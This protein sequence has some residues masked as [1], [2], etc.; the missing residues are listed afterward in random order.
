VATITKR[1][2]L[3]WQAKIR[4]KGYPPQSR[5][6]ETKA[7]AEVWARDIE[8]EM[9]RGIFVDRGEAESTTLYDALER[10]RREVTPRK[11][12]ADTETGRI[13]RWQA[14]T[15]SKSTLARI[16]GKDLAKFRDDRRAEGRAENTIRLDLALLSSLYET[17]RKEWGM[18]AL[19]NPVRMIKAPG[20]SNKRERRLSPE[21]EKWLLSGI[22]AAM[23]RT[24]TIRALVQLALETGMRQSEILGIEWDDVDLKRKFVRLPDTKSG[25]PRDVPL[26]PVALDVLQAMPRSISGGRMFALSQDQLIRG[27]RA[28]RKKGRELYESDTGEK[29]PAGLLDNL[30]FHD[31]RHEAASRWAAVLAAQELAKMFGWKTLQMALRYYHPT[32]ESLAEKLARAHLTALL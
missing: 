12:G 23:P 14:H 18:E 28:A 1:G 10:Y 15:L 2:D 7:D 5:T 30:R 20:G 17:A 11:K 26:S 29:P 27:F 8:R 31:L 22:E 16:R 21:E 13:R 4:R 24:P 32:G 9:D 19:H 3:Q 6:F 25:D